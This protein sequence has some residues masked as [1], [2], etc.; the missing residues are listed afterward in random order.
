MNNRRLDAK[1]CDDNIL[2]GTLA[3][4]SLDELKSRD[5][6]KFVVVAPS[7]RRSVSCALKPV[8]QT[9]HPTIGW[10]CTTRAIKMLTCDAVTC[11]FLPFLTLPELRILEFST[12]KS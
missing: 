10:E 6:S 5:A 3:L 8:L 2:L 1:H 7:R 4:N 9:L 12:Q 11:F